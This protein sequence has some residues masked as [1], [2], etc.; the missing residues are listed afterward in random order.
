MGHHFILYSLQHGQVELL[1]EG[2]P[3][4][5]GLGLC[6]KFLKQLSNLGKVK[7]GSDLLLTLEKLKHK[8]DGLNWF[9]DKGLHQGIIGK[10]LR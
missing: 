7:V 4:H 10:L 8:L 6:S 3:H 9:R 2:A 1:S 5:V